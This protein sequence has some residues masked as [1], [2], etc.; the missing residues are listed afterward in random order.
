MKILK[1]ALAV[2]LSV[3][4]VAFSFPLTSFALPN[5]NNTDGRY[6]YDD[7]VIV[8]TYV[9]DYDGT[10]S[11]GY[12]SNNYFDNHDGAGEVPTYDLKHLKKSDLASADGTFALVVTVENVDTADCLSMIWSYPKGLADNDVVPANYSGKRDKLTT[13]EAAGR[14]C[15]LATWADSDTYIDASDTSGINICAM[16]QTLAVI[17]N[18][19]PHEPWPNS[20][21]QDSENPDSVF[22]GQMLAV[23][24]LQ[25]KTDEVDLTQALALKQNSGDTFINTTPGSD[26]KDLVVYNSLNDMVTGPSPRTQFIMPEWGLQP[27]ETS[28]DVTYTYN[29]VGGKSTTVT[30]PAGQT[31]TAPENTP[32]VGPTSD[33][34]G[35]HTTKTYSWPDFVEGTTTYDEIETVN[36]VSCADTMV[37]TEAAVPATHT[38]PGKTAV[39]KCSVCGYTTGGEVIPA[40]PSAHDW[41]VTSETD[42]TCTVKGEIHYSCVCG[43][44]KT[45]YKDLDPNNHT[46]IVTDDAVAATCVATGLTAGSHCA[47]CNV[48]IVAQQQTPIDKTNHVGEIKTGVNAKEA[49]RGED[50]YTGDSVCAACGDVV[51]KGQV[52]PATGVMITV[53]ASDKGTTTLN[54]EA[55]TGAAQKVA[56]EKEYTLTATPA[57]N[58]KFVGWEVNGKLVSNQAT[59]TTAAFA[60]VTYT[61]VF[62]A[63]EAKAFN[64]TFVDQFNNVIAKMSN[65]EVAALD[66]MPTPYE[67]KGFTFKGWSMDLDAVKALQGAATV[68]A[69]YSKDEAASYTVTAPEGCTIAVAGQDMGTSATV[70]HDAKVT[71]KAAN[72][73]TWKINGKDAAYGSEYTFFVT[74]DVNVEFVEGAVT[75]QPVVTAVAAEKLAA[76]KAR[77]LATRSVPEDYN[78]LESGF[79]FGK[80][81]A[82]PATLVLENVGN[83]AYLYKNSNTAADGQ[84]ALTLKTTAASVTARAYIIVEKA[85]VT[86]VIYAEPQTAFLGA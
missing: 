71:V 63:D 61:P 41:K 33:K 57:A 24:G 11:W 49:T 23:F 65:T 8:H 77:F 32:A 53:N 6:S 80:D 27:E 15:V 66:A 28:T 17:L 13:G 3:L 58:A 34:A 56:Y 2:L 22:K 74:A 16:K 40:D 38:T 62:A 10:D 43:E 84:F 68:V 50:G 45:E 60:D 36:T 55:T 85:G 5:P 70:S 46:N 54:G 26:D 29:Y 44:T 48:V 31:P 30:V 37:E 4:M 82:D 73:G 35:K 83:G 86:Q 19:T 47:D 76:N 51:A 39:Q 79:V 1:K 52:I 14:S 59:Y 64:V 20:Y 9:V 7:D 42:S 25:M 78:L 69:S 21:Q 72:E 75:A 67:Y 12:N 18:R 81:V